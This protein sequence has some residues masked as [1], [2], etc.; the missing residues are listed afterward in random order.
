MKS[1]Y[2]RNVSIAVVMTLVLVSAAQKSGAA[3]DQKSQQAVDRIASLFSSTSSIATVK[4]QIS[5]E[6]GQ[7][8]LSMKIWSLGD[9]VLVRI[10]QPQDE[11]GTAILK[12]GSDIKYYLPKS[13]RTVHIPASMAMTSW[14]GSDFTIDD[15]VKEPFLTRDYSIGTSYEGK[16]G[17]VAVY[18]Y[19]LTPKSDAAVVW[20]KIVLQFRQADGVPTW[21]GYYGDDGKLARELTF[22]EYKKESGRL[23]PTHLVMKSE[24]KGGAQTSIDYE[25]IA[26][27]VPISKGTFSLPNDSR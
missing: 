22:S 14:M 18:E 13:N 10:T 16:R 27:D 6:D 4:M 8:D 25:D 2:A 21:Q 7:R 1:K 15:L 17:G 11:A 12:Q 9:K 26:F 23:I 19:T 20:G 24:D 5:N 3:Q